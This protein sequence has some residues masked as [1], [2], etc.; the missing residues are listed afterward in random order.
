MQRQCLKNFQALNEINSHRRKVEDKYMLKKL[1]LYRDSLKGN[2]KT[3][4]EKEQYGLH[5]FP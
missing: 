4:M 3:G 2:S 1:W 5:I